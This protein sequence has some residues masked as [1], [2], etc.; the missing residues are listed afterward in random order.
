[1][2]AGAGGGW[3]DWIKGIFGGASPQ[4]RPV[5]TNIALMGLGGSAGGLSQAVGSLG[6]FGGT[7]LNFPSFSGIGSGIGGSALGGPSGNDPTTFYPGQFGGFGGVGNAVGPGLNIGGLGNFGGFDPTQFRGPL[8]TPILPPQRAE[9]HPGTTPGGSSPLPPGA[10]APDNYDGSAAATRSARI[11]P[12]GYPG[13]AQRFNFSSLG[14]FA[15]SAPSTPIR[16]TQAGANPNMQQWFSRPQQPLWT[17]FANQPQQTSNYDG[18]A[19]AAA[20]ENNLTEAERA[21]LR[22]TVI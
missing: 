1:M 11:A 8:P 17:G 22:R 2:P 10:P 21:G 16:P 15:P 4:T 13:L 12:V 19:A 20:R 6:N 18:T 3:V 9:N 14:R 7:S 5:M